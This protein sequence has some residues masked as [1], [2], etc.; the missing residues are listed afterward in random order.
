MAILHEYTGAYL[1]GRPLDVQRDDDVI[2]GDTSPIFVSRMSIF[3]DACEELAHQENIRFPMEVTFFG[4]QAQD[5]GG[6]RR[7]FFE[8]VV[9]IIKEKVF[10]AREDKVLIIEDD[11]M[12]SRR[13]LFYAGLI[14][15]KVYNYIY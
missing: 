10:V 6:P 7:E 15:G 5:L 13:T 1:R 2:E 4:E 11:E 12:L 9:G 14:L 3:E 8:K